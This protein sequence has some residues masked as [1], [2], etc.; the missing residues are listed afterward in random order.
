MPFKVHFYVALFLLNSYT[1]FSTFGSQA[2]NNLTPNKNSSTE[3]NSNINSTGNNSA[4]VAR[5]HSDVMGTAIMPI[6]SNSDSVYPRQTIKTQQDTAALAAAAAVA[7]IERSKEFEQ[8]NSTEN[9]RGNSHSIL[10]L[11]HSLFNCSHAYISRRCRILKTMR[12]ICVLKIVLSVSYFF[13]S[14]HCGEQ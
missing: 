13:F 1:M 10:F 6:H 9:E 3:N 14:H 11:Q 4:A 5:S 8:R 7:S 2:R 12:V